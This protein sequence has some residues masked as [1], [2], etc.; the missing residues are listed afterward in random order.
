MGTLAKRPVYSQIGSEKK[1]KQLL[2][3]M[4]R[5]DLIP[6]SA[7]PKKPSVQDVLNAVKRASLPVQT[8]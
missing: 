7:I 3:R 8:Q 1:R 2:D 6:A 5:Q 4:R